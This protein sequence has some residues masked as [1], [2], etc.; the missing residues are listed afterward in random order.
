MYKKI[1]VQTKSP[2]HELCMLNLISILNTLKSWLGY[3]VDHLPTY[4]QL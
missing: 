2:S 1:T 4:A 3:N